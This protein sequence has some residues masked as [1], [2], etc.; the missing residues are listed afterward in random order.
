MHLFILTSLS[1]VAGNITNN[2][3]Q[4]RIRLTVET[5]TFEYYTN[6]HTVYIGKS[7]LLK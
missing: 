1:L 4:V 5:R 3:I 7:A 2:L 6:I